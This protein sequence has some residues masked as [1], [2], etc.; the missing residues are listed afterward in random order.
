MILIYDIK[1]KFY[2]FL[3]ISNIFLQI[4]YKSNN[5]KIKNFIFQIEI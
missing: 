2:K 1:F 4:K 5:K 3:F